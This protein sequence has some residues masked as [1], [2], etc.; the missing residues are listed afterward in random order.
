LH[1]CV[2]AG[3]WQSGRDAKHVH[4]QRALA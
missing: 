4:S 2:M 1:H 3:V